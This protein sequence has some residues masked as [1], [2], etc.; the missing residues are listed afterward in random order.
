MGDVT[1]ENHNSRERGDI[2]MIISLSGKIFLLIE[3]R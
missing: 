1:R 3:I 2:E